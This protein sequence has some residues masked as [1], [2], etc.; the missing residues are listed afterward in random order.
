MLRHFD[1]NFLL[2]LFNEEKKNSWNRNATGDLSVLIFRFRFFI[3]FS[4]VRRFFFI[5]TIAKKFPISFVNGIKF[6]I[7]I[8]VFSFYRRRNRFQL[9]C[10][11]K[12]FKLNINSFHY[13]SV[14]SFIF[15]YIYFHPFRFDKKM[16]CYLNAIRFFYEFMHSIWCMHIQKLFSI[17]LPLL[18]VRVDFHFM[19]LLKYLKIGF[20]LSL[21]L[22]S[23]LVTKKKTA[24]YLT[25][26]Q[27]E[28]CTFPHI[29]IEKL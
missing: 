24:Y 10:F 11:I 25:Y 8:L 14:H 19:C 4:M 5:N 13:W 16:F 28:C 18:R 15:F 2:L 29:H 26:H 6:I 27:R 20:V 12:L 7:N 9:F 22:N 23:V 17:F 1:N 21:N 3:F